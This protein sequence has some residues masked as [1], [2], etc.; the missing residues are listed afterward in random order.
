M[1]VLPTSRATLT[2][3]TCQSCFLQRADESKSVAGTSCV[4][5][6]PLNR[7][8]KTI[9]AGGESGRT[10]FGMLDYVIKH[11]PS[12]VV[13]ENVSGAPWDEVVERFAEIDYDAAVL[14]LD[15]KHYYIPHTRTR[16]C[17]FVLLKQLKHA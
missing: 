14:R 5:Y 4:D 13:L 15:T 17:T 16:G 12:I 9:D 3:C 2:C 1:V 11:Q 8:K 6:S 7:L 10:F